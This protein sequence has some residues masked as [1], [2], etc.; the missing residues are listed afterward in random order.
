MAQKHEKRRG[1]E[2]FPHGN[3][4]NFSINCELKN[5]LP[6]KGLLDIPLTQRPCSLTYFQRILAG[7]TMW[8]KGNV[9]YIRADCYYQQTFACLVSGHWRDYR[10]DFWDFK[11]LVAN[12]EKS[13][14]HLDCVITIQRSSLSN[15]LL[16]VI[17]RFGE[18]EQW[19]YDQSPNRILGKTCERK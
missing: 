12:V 10:M 3:M 18:V 11:G 5:N 14:W 8:L 17:S 13:P 19:T 6:S 1:K 7:E 16:I 2:F 4:S 9:H 15:K